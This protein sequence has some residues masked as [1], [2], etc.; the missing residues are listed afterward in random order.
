MRIIH[1]L[2]QFYKTNE[3]GAFHEIF[4]NMPFSCPKPGFN[5]LH[6]ESHHGS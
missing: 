3:K 4:S 1:C 5:Q 6:T 2:F